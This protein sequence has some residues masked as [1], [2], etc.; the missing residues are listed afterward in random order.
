MADG[1]ESFLERECRMN[2]AHTTA[3]VLGL[4]LSA[5]LPARA[6]S[7]VNFSGTWELD[8]GRSV[9]P[10]SV[11]SVIPGDLSLV[12]HHEGPTLKIERQIKMLGMHR[13]STSTFYTDGRE[14]SNLT[15]RGETVI[16][17]SHW[18]GA[19]LV[20]ASKGTVTLEGKKQAVET[21]DVRQL[22]EDG[23]VL[24]VDTTIRRAGQEPPERTHIVFV[25][26]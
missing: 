15:Q 2:L 12:I 22:S 26:K 21:T 9:F 7:P 17:Q 20:T 6:E 5:V 19:S 25:R 4:F 11:P 24:V 14:A 3:L 10:P 8:K 13:T 23:K 1:S 16:S 18:E